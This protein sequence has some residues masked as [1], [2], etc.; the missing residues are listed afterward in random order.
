MPK[1]KVTTAAALAILLI[2]LSPAVRGYEALRRPTELR[3][4]SESKAYG[5]YTLF[6]ARGVTY[7]I[8]MRGSVIHTWPIGMNPRLLENGNL[9]DAVGSGLDALSG[10]RELDWKGSPVWEY[11]ETRAGYAPH[12]DFIR[13]NNPKLKA[14]TTLY[15]ASKSV[16]HEEA[17]AA[18]CSP[19][20]GPYTGAR[21]DV[22]VEVDTSGKVIWEWSF[23][24]HGIQDADASRANYAGSGKTVAAYPGKINLNLPGRPL[25]ASWLECNS[26]DY[27]EALDQIV[28]NSAQG[29][30]YVIDHGNTFIAGNPS[31]SVALAAS[32]AG[33][34]LYRFGD[35]A[36]YK[37]G[38]PPSV[39]KDWTNATAGNKQMGGS[40][41]V[42]W[43]RSG[44]SGAGNFLILNNGQYLFERTSQ[45]SV[46]QVSP[47]RDSTGSTT[48]QYVNPPQAGYTTVQ[49]DRDTH[50]GPRKIS[51]Q[52]VWSFATKSNQGLFSPVGS[53]CQRLPNGNTL[54]CSMAAGQ[55]LEVTADGELVWDYINP[56][57]NTGVLDSIT[58]GYASKNPVFRAW[59]YGADHAAL[60][61]KT[62]TGLGTLTAL[63][64]TAYFPWLSF[65][66]G[67]ST[68]GI[69]LVNPAASQATVQLTGYDAAGAIA[70]TAGTVN[71]APQGQTAFQADAQ[72]GLTRATDAW[73]KAEFS[74]PGMQGLF[75][76]QLCPRGY[77]AGMDGAPMISATTTDGIIPRARSGLGYTTR[78]ALS[79]PGETAVSVTISGTSGTATYDGGSHSLAARACLYLDVAALFR[80]APVFDGF[81][82]VRATGGV[83]GSAQIRYDS[84]ALSSVNLLL[85]SRAS[86]RL[87]APH[88]AR[89]KGLYYSEVS[90]VNPGETEAV[91]LLSAFGPDGAA[92][93]SP[94]T[95]R[96][97]ARGMLLLRDEELGLASS[98][99]SDGWLLVRSTTGNPLLA[100]ISIGHPTDSHYESFLPLPA[101]GSREYTFGQVA[102]GPVGGVDYWTGIAVLNPTAQSAQVTFRICKSNGDLNGNEVSVSLGAGKKYVGL[103]SG[104][105]GI[106]TL[107][108]QAGGYLSL[109]ATEPVL[110][111][112]LFG[113][114]SGSFLSAVPAPF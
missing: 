26:L 73:I 103:L 75:L 34:F 6:A 61:G 49:Y 18:G 10:F 92:L 87:Y 45:S 101:E 42:Q 8:D 13:I 3:F 83:I 40:N 25:R 93:A 21:V 47:F 17:L 80:T 11:Y 99:P 27:N 37:Q 98:G 54:I 100:G 91:A 96:V 44:L 109:Q 114:A 86:S 56:V 69:A 64:R 43:I 39:L 63:S 77:L 31:G 22:I 89:V 106:G 112:Q 79:N 113:D 102:N 30:F 95:A 104:L 51:N 20:K 66:P 72:L 55:I 29:E 65:D 36:R 82:R 90:L 52:V 62:L 32:P 74:Q 12:H 57:T 24:D 2:S 15:L 7:L 9:L 23:L 110:A 14:A 58:D 4:W 16:T 60:A 59:R 1:S 53:S 48:G 5:G 33:D 76:A 19:A 28:V 41:H 84:E 35:P 50:K 105:P 85:V 67:R 108:S 78:L 46:I 97:P 70:G 111:F 94:V 81:L 107:S 71:L 88:L 68:T 38:D